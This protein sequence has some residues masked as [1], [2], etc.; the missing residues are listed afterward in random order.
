MSGVERFLAGISSEFCAD[1]A[2][3]G[4]GVDLTAALAS[5]NFSE[6]LYGDSGSLHSYWSSGRGL[7][8]SFQIFLSWPESGSD[9]FVELTFFP[10][11]VN[12]TE[13]EITKFAALTEQWCQTLGAAAFFVRWEN[14]SWQQFDA[15]AP[16]VFFTRSNRPGI[17]MG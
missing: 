17:A 16:D 10:E 5:K 8:S 1:N 15:S 3:N 14:A 13:F 6:A 11:D 12:P 7:L 9:V 2:F 4:D